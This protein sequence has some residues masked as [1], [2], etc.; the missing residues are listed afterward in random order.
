MNET[1]NIKARYRRR[2]KSKT[3]SGKRYFY[4]D[5]YSRQERDKL[6]E[7]IIRKRFGK[8][9]SK[10]KMIEIGA[11]Y[12]NN[13]PF[14]LQLGVSPENIVANE[15]LEERFHMLQKDFP[16]VSLYP[17]DAMDL[18][19][20]DEFD[21]VYVSLVFSSVLD[22]D[23]KKNLAYKIYDMLKNNRLIL[24]YDFI[25]NNPLNQDVRGIKVKEIISLFPEA[26][27]VTAHHV[28]LL[29]LLARMTGRLYNFIN[30]AFP[31]LRTHVVA[32]IYKL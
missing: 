12:G 6:L 32:E 15:L 23:Y 26:S 9:L 7:K 27:Q 17:G 4:F 25:Y 8:D 10:I 13:L 19:F 29:P 5:L 21:I 22:A 1:E 28:T 14:F 11:G 20:S 3:R 24:W 18:P 31:F 30:K 16:E 2:D